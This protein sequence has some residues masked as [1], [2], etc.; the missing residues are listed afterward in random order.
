[1]GVWADTY[2][3]ANRAEMIGFG[4]WGNKSACP[5]WSVSELA[6]ILV[7]V[8]LERHDHYT[9]KARMAA[10][11]SRKRGVGRDVAARTVLELLGEQ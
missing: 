2:D 8:V 7:D 6:P 9:A 5:R 4:R 10:E 3:Y 11:T 1:M